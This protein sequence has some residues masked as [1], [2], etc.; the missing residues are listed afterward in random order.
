MQPTTLDDNQQA[1][2]TSDVTGELPRELEDMMENWA[3]WLT[4]SSG[5]AGRSGG[6]ESKWRSCPHHWEAADDGKDGDTRPCSLCQGA[7]QFAG[8]V[9]ESQARAVEAAV[10]SLPAVSGKLLKAHYVRR[11]NPRRTARGLAIHQGRYDLEVRAA[12]FTV[13]TILRMQGKY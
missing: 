5:P 9:N 12:V 1:Y 4:T 8:E 10:V 7:P 13:H 11:S 6:L 2:D 3:R